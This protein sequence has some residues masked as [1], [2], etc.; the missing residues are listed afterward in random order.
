MRARLALLALLALAGCTDDVVVRPVID[1]P[2]PGSKGAAFA[3]LDTIEL[4]VALEG[5]QE[6]LVSLLF[7]RGETLELSGVPYGENLVV[8]MLGRVNS[9]EVAYGR[10]CRFAVRAGESPPSPHL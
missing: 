3:D 7:R 6:P 9:A 2:P 10:T 5:E 4:S 8:H 1:S